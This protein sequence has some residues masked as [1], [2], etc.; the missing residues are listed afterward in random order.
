MPA[1]TK[2]TCCPKCGAPIRLITLEPVYYSVEEDGSHE[3]YNNE[4]WDQ[5][6]SMHYQCTNRGCDH[7]F[8]TLEMR[9]DAT[10]A[11]RAYIIDLHKM[12]VLT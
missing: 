12:E 3:N 4:N 1:E 2:H 5:N 9:K 6:L 10:K 8:T 7:E 11:L